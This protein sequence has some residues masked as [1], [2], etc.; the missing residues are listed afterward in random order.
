LGRGRLEKT[1]RRSLAPG[2][3]F[4]LG[5]TLGALLAGVVAALLLFPGAAPWVLLNQTGQ[6]I[7]GALI[8][9]LALAIVVLLV[10]RPLRWR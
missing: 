3:G 8:G 2:R 9:G 4:R 6:K 1:S 10:A 5:V 7:S